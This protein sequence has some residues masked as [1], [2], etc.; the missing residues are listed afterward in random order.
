MPAATSTPSTAKAKSLS[1]SSA[2]ARKRMF[3]T[4]D[5][6]NRHVYWTDPVMKFIDIAGSR[7]ASSASPLI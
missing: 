2:N 6:V 7:G 4:L 1:S 5:A 3:P